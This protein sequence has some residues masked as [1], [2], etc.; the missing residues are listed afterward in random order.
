MAAPTQ[1]ID[2][3]DLAEHLRPVMLKFSR[4]LRREAQNIGVSAL[5][6]QILGVIRKHPGLGISELAE[7]E[8]TS[9][10]AMSVH[11]KRLE[12]TGWLTRESDGEEGDGRRVR[13][14]VTAEGKKTLDA[15]RRQ[16]NDWLQ[17]RLARLDAA[18]LAALHAAVDP[19]LRL[20][21]GR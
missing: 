19:L 16:R 1:P 14:I 8:Q 6:S 11:V 7:I 18:D 2:L 17:A 9:R 4:H 20:V 15:V 3:N 12:A 5:D 21:E 13:L 10:P